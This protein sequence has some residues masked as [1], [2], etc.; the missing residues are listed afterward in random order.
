MIPAGRT[1]NSVE[2]RIALGPW[3]WSLMQ[4]GT[5]WVFP[6]PKLDAPR[7]RSCWY[8]A[9]DR[10]KIVVPIGTGVETTIYQRIINFEQVTAIEAVGVPVLTDK[11]DIANAR[12]RFA[13]GHRAMD[14]PE[15]MRRASS[16]VRARAGMSSSTVPTGRR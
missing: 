15:V 4:T 7:S 9:R 1:K 6:A 12:L 8:K 13:T 2:H 3:G 10:V 5:E 14:C 16:S 11:F